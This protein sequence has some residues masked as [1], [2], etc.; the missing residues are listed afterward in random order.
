[1]GEGESVGEGE[2]G[3]GGGEG[4]VGGEG[5]SGRGGEVRVEW[6]KEGEVTVGEKCK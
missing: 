3:R 6:E 2:S 5:E 1:M 4:R